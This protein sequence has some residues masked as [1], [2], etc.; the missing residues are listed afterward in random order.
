MHDNHPTFN[1]IFHRFFLFVINCFD[2]IVPQDD[3]TL[4]PAINTLPV[5]SED[6]EDEISDA[7]EEEE[8]KQPP[9][10]TKPPTEEEDTE[11]TEHSSTS[12]LLNKFP[13]RTNFPNGDIIG[14]LRYGL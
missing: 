10:V 13:V 6:E 2:V 1:V 8:V 14:G 5:I 7:E 12:P 4:L 3:D 9:V 11:Q